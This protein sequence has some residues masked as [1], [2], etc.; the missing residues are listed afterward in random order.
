MRY[1]VFLL[2]TLSCFLNWGCSETPE[3]QLEHINGYWEIVSATNAKGVSKSYPPGRNIDYIE[4]TE[5]EGFRKKLQPD[6]RGNYSTSKSQET[7]K[8]EIIDD[9]LELVYRTPFSSWREK[10]MRANVKKLI[11][12]NDNGIEYTYERHAPISIE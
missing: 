6:I 2:V 4:I 10:V 9:R 5:G 7:I 3:S 1:T 11:I 8:A 12:K